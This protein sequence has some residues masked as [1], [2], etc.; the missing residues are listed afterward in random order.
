MDNDNTLNLDLPSFDQG[1]TRAAVR[2]AIIRTAFTATVALL[3]LMLVLTLASAGWS[4]RTSERARFILGRAYQSA[5]PGYLINFSSGPRSRLDFGTDVR[6]GAQALEPGGFSNVA[7]PITVRLTFYGR[8]SEYTV[9]PITEI[10]ALFCCIGRSDKSRAATLLKSLPAGVELSARVELKEPLDEAAFS[11]FRHKLGICGT[12]TSLENVADPFAAE[13]R[14][15]AEANACESAREGAE[16]AVL[17]SLVLSPTPQDRSH[18][19]ETDADGA[20]RITW[21]DFSLVEFNRWASAL[22]RADE[23]NIRRMLLPTVDEIKRRAREA[24]IYAFVV[25]GLRPERLQALLKAPEFGDIT[26][27]D[28]ALAIA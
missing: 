17:R 22:R 27:A 15:A 1:A 3:A 9:L 2:R 13:R 28:V 18:K 20:H 5:N 6:G 14:Y 19:L 26:I 25:T 12:N 24:K 8:I 4:V 21:P 10:D 23:P 16:T 7:T 11:S